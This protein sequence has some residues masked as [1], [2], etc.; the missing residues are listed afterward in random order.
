[1]MNSINGTEM[2]PCN[3]IG[4]QGNEP[5]CPRTMHNRGIINRDGRWIELERDFGPS[6]PVDKLSKPKV[7]CLWDQFT[8]EEKSKPMG[9]SCPCP[10]CSTWCGS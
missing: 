5:Y 3:C 6:T 4:R 8:E 7:P 10:K 9:L 2:T 1:M